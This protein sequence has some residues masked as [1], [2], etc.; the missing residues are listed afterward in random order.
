MKSSREKQ[1][2]VGNNFRLTPFQEQL[3]QS[4]E[5]FSRWQK[6]GLSD[7]YQKRIHNSND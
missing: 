6:K 4:D 2:S 7:A 1:E 5:K 3:L